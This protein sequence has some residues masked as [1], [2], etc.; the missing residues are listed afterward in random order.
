MGANGF[1]SGSFKPA[2]HQKFISLIGQQNAFLTTFDIYATDEE[3]QLLASALKAPS[4][5]Q[6]SAFR[7]VAIA[8]AYGGDLGKISGLEWFDTITKKIDALKTVEDKIAK[9]LLSLTASLK[10]QAQA[11]L[12]WVLIIVSAMLVFT[13]ILITIIIRGITKP[14]SLMTYAMGEL[15]NGDLDMTVPALNQKDEIGDMAKAVNIFKQHAIDVERLNKDRLELEHKSALEKSQALKSMADTVEN[16]VSIAVDKITT[17]STHIEDMAVRL[18]SNSQNVLMHSND[19]SEAAENALNLS[20]TVA[21]T[22]AELS[23][24]INEIS[25]QVAQSTTITQEAVQITNETHQIV[26]SLHDSANKVG[27]VIGLIGDIAE[28]T[29]LLAL[30][31]TIEA[32]RAGDAGKGFAVVASEVKSLASQT[33][34]STT[35]IT[36][37]VETMQSITKQ[38]V[39]AINRIN[40]TISDVNSVSGSISAAVEEQS[41]ATNNIAEHI[42]DLANSSQQISSHIASVTDQVQ[43]VENLSKE[44][45]GTSTSM[46]DQIG[47][48]N[49]IV[50]KIIR[51]SSDDVNR[52][53]HNDP[54]M[55]PSPDRRQ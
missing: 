6:V 39:E 37:Q 47:S 32:A 16:E 3:R 29:N 48:L 35:E 43:G 55:I 13:L 34:N 36:A 5:D 42:R 10:Q 19:V 44:M 41:A 50:T 45:E 51:G 12:L 11:T 4:V 24:A 38:A 40:T 8:N 25:S 18:A 53:Q 33:Q 30:N 31:A 52:R 1:G 20:D 27:D 28:Q 7:K 15:A 21:G 46:K 9:N 2:I 17:E 23:A 49:S 22:A 26:S 14:L 54:S